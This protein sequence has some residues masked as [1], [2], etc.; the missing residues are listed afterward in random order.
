MIFVV[1]G[2]HEHGFDRLVKAVDDIAKTKLINDFFIQIGYSN[3][4]PKYCKWTKAIDFYEF[5]ERMNQ[6]EL[7]ITHGG[8]GCIAGA[9]EKC[10]K[11]IVVPRLKKFNEHNNDHQLELTSVLEETGR[12]LAC[13]NMEDLY[14]IITKGQNFNP[15]PALG[16]NSIVE[17]IKQYLKDLSE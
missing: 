11:T 3:Y 7:V 14:S 8:A 12:V 9:L 5:E 10:K 1:T 17:I 2:V 13:Y 16:D 6:A 4:K 15:T